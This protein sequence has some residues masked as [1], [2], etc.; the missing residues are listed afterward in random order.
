MTS[1][2]IVA[3]TGGELA[4]FKPSADW[5]VAVVD[6]LKNL[7]SERTRK[8]YVDAWRDFFTFT[9]GKSPDLVSQS[10]V[11]DYRF[12]LKTGVS[13]KTRKPFAQSTVNQRLSALSSF[14]VFAQG[15]GLRADNPVDGVKREAV[16]PYGRATFLDVEA[17]EDIALIEAI[18]TSTDQGKR[19]F[20]LFLLYLTGGFRVSEAVG[21]KVGD[22]RRQGRRLFVTYKRKGGEIEEIPVADEAGE[23][24]AVYFATRETLTDDSPVF[25]ATD[26]G[27]RAA[28]AIGRYGEEEKP[29]TTRAIRYLLDTYAT[30]VFGPGH[31]LRPHSLRHTAA[32]ALLA[33]GG[34][35]T[36]VSRLLK[37][38]SM[39]VTTI[40]VHS[41]KNSDRKVADVLGRRYGRA[42]QAAD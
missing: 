37:H 28:K 31:G 27:R 14:F 4:T 30:K 1:D 41:T 7:D 38:K 34:S 8:A 3:P 20:A 24:L 36:E 15:R 39:A 9:G 23:A 6:W 35:I 33:E 40:Y 22:L 32:Q 21:L 10:D 29:L 11:I 42:I 26:K 19:D 25:V 5:E 16:S 18:D 12:S 2:I 17:G 13:P